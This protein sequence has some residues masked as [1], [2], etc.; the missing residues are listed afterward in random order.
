MNLFNPTQTP[1]ATMMESVFASS[2]RA[3]GKSILSSVVARS[4]WH[5]NAVQGDCATH[6]TTAEHSGSPEGLVPSHQ[7][8]DQE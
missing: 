4:I 3:N 5:A 6:S 1:T 7:L 2:R 8:K